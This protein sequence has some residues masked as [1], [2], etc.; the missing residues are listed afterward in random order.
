M[1]TLALRLKK[2]L[3]WSV[4]QCFTILNRSASVEFDAQVTLLNRSCICSCV[5]M[6]AAI[7]WPRKGGKLMVMT[8]RVTTPG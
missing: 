3:V 5:F 4:D 2:M 8:M 7:Y 6:V 1:I